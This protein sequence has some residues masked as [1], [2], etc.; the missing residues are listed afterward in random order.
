MFSKNSMCKESL[1]FFHL[2]IL[3]GSLIITLVAQFHIKRK[4]FGMENDVTLIASSE[5]VESINPVRIAK[6]VFIEYS[7][8]RC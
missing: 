7:I 4:V 8:T 1:D 5:P 2:L 6:F 3:S